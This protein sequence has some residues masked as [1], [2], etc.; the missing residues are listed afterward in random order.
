MSSSNLECSIC[1]YCYDSSLRQPKLL[2]CSHSFCSNCLHSLVTL[3]NRCCPLCRAY[4]QGSVEDLPICY[5]LI[6]EGNAQMPT[7]VMEICAE[8][9]AEKALWCD[10]CQAVLCQKCIRFLH[11]HCEWMLVTE[12]CTSLRQCQAVAVQKLS[13]KE[14]DLKIKLKKNEVFFASITNFSSMLPNLQEAVKD[15]Q[16]KL[17]TWK[18]NVDV[19]TK[20]Y[21]SM[22]NEYDVKKLQE[23]LHSL[24]R[25]GTLP[26]PDGPTTLLLHII[27]SFQVMFQMMGKLYFS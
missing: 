24:E 11:K 3:G 23:K 2:P 5:Q 26:V 12:K 17:I 22:S 21:P 14:S 18:D 9:N 13:E 25:L 27:N 15:Y 19:E 20:Q 4:W 7:R 6:S 1:D 8:H 16:K 10:S